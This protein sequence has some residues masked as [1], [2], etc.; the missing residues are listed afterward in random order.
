MIIQVDCKYEVLRNKSALKFTHIDMQ[1][2]W[3]LKAGSP[4]I[5]SHSIANNFEF[6]RSQLMMYIFGILL[7]AHFQ[8][9]FD[10]TCIYCFVT[11]C[12]LT[13]VYIH[14]ENRFTKLMSFGIN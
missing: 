11:Q 13:L 3:N 14:Y 7:A 8:S 4:C 1:K 2:I 12:T 10:K 6:E 5:I 9:F